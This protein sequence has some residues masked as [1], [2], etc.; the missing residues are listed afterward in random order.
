MDVRGTTQSVRRRRGGLAWGLFWALDAVLI[1]VFAFGFSARYVPPEILWWRELLAIGQP[2][3]SALLLVPT[4]VLLVRRRWRGVALHVLLLALAV[5]R[6]APTDLWIE[7]PAAEGG[8]ALRVMTLN[9]PWAPED[10]GID[11]TPL[12]RAEAPD[13]VAL[14]ESYFIHTDRSQRPN[15][16][17]RAVMDSLDAYRP[18]MGP[19]EPVPGATRDTHPLAARVATHQPVIGTVEV[20]ESQ[21][22]PLDVERARQ[23]SP[24][25]VIRVRF[26]WDGREAVLYN[27]H[28]RSFGVSKVW[29]EESSLFSLDLWRRYLGRYR[30]AFL[31]R[32]EEVRHVRRMMAEETAP[33]LLAGDFNST[34]HNWT[35]AYL[36]DGLQDAFAMAG[37][38][39]GGTYHVRY[40][41]VRIDYVLAEPA[42]EVVHAD[43]INARVS[44]HRPLVVHLRWR[45]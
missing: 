11:L 31:L 1:A 8:E 29:N 37:T 7:E 10:A 44:D 36:A 6:H 9:L 17:V 33:V 22:V 42:W 13:L 30:D 2:L 25:H 43:V 21:L 32:A 35:Y 23:F 16:E 14:Q 34:P 15:N 27:L 26:L 12:F 40:P 20:L 39:W 19:F 41:F 18:L 4:A 38:G 24:A 28:L 45:E 3:W 5:W